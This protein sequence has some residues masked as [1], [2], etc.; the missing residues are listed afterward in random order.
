MSDAMDEVREAL[1]AQAQEQAHGWSNWTSNEA[2]KTGFEAGVDAALF[3]LYAQDDPLDGRD[4]VVNEFRMDELDAVMVSVDKWFDDGDPRLA[5]NPATRA[6]DAR[7]IALKAIEEAR[8]SASGQRC[9]KC[10]YRQRAER[11]EVMQVGQ[12][13]SGQGEA[14]RECDDVTITP[15][16]IGRLVGTLHYEPAALRSRLSEPQP[17][18]ESAEEPDE[19]RQ[20]DR[21][22][23]A[24]HD[25]ETLRKAAER[26]VK[27]AYGF[28][29]TAEQ[30]KRHAATLRVAILGEGKDKANHCIE[31][32]TSLRDCAGMCSNKGGDKS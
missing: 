25:A 30:D 15:Q 27:A 10:E 9:D 26:A 23:L 16:T 19:I 7:E 29:S 3:R 28:G 22:G 18:S 6:A 21:A 5:Q 31:C 13:A 32:M 12:S 20:F 4:A 14:H 24:A 8:L 1:Y 17:A 11:A 2:Y